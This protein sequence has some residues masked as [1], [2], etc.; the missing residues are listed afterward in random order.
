MTL[1]ITTNWTKD[2]SLRNIKLK[3]KQLDGWLVYNAAL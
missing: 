2:E 1:T 3:P